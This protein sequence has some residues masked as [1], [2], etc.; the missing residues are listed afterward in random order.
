TGILTDLP[1]DFTFRSAIGPRVYIGAQWLN[2]TGVVQPGSMVGYRAYLA[3]R[4][5]AEMERRVEQSAQ[6]LR[7]A[8]LRVETADEQAQEL[9]SPIDA[10]GRFLGLSGLAALLLGGLGVASAVGVFVREK[11]AVIATLRCIGATQRT[12]FVAYL[13]QAALLGLAGAA[14]GALLGIGVQAA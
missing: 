7:A 6:R 13:L 14:A 1:A 4:E 3:S 8:G 9:A 12:A 11:R 10:P 2:A 5:P